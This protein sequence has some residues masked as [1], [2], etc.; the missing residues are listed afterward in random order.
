MGGP[1][2]LGS[3]TG[4]SLQEQYLQA[5]SEAEK[6]FVSPN[7]P[8]LSELSNS[9]EI[10]AA[11]T[12]QLPKF[13]GNSMTSNVRLVLVGFK[14]T[15]IDVFYVP[16]SLNDNNGNNNNNSNNNNG[17]LNVNVGDLVLVEAD[18]GRDLAITTIS[19]TSIAFPKTNCP[20]CL[21]KRSIT[22]IVEES[23]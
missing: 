4:L 18:R 11:N 23:R 21:S 17:P 12:S 16:D 6:Y 5:Y 2:G 3:S 13:Q 14:N 20:F 15:R 7:S 19:T 9:L 22:I 8:V 10:L 1:M